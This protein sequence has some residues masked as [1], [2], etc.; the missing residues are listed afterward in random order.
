MI[1]ATHGILASAGGIVYDADA[2]A[3]FDRVTTAGGTLSTTEKN[4]VNQ[5]VLDLKNYSIWNS[6]KAIYPMVGASAAACAQNLKSSSFTGS[7]SGG[8]T[9]A[10][11]GVT[12]N[13][14]T[15]FMNTNLNPSSHLL[16]NSAHLSYYSRSNILNTGMDIGIFDGTLSPVQGTHFSISYSGN[17]GQFRA[18]LNS[19]TPSTTYTPTDG[20][21][22]YCISRIDGTNFKG[23]R[24]GTSQ[25]TQSSSTGT[26]SSIN[27][28][29]GAINTQTG[30]SDF[31][32]HQ[33]AFSS[34]GDGLTDTEASNFNTAVNAFQT[35]LSRNV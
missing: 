22:F 30:A 12:P 3:F 23:Y 8:W 21:G 31:A 25:F 19:S 1:I 29:I 32:N 34:I 17:S 13:G 14:T 10:S 6:M 11:T 20:R 4:A 33:C 24:N 35:T 5:L 2:Q 28:I 18:R 9:Y 26:R 7:F 27:I 16:T 15:G